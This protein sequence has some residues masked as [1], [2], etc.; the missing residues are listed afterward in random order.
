MVDSNIITLDTNDLSPASPKNGLW[1]NRLNAYYQ[2]DAPGVPLVSIYIIGYNRIEKTKRAVG[3]VLKYTTDIDYEL[4]LIDNGSSDDTLDFFKSVEHPKK[5]I[6]HVTKNLGAGYSFHTVLNVFKGKYLVG[7]SNDIYVTQNWLSNSLK[8]LESDP[9]IGFIEPVSSNVSNLQQHDFTFKDFDEMQEKAAKFNVSDPSKWEE[10]MRLIS[11]LAVFRREILDIVG[12]GDPAFVHDFSEDDMCARIRRAGY[13]LVLCKDTWI[14]HDHDFRH[15]EDKTAETFQATLES[16]RAIYKEKYWGIDAW[17]DMSNFEFNLLEPVDGHT[18]AD[19]TKISAL[20][21]DVKCGTPILEIRN[22][23]R[24]RGMTVAQSFA[25]TTQA[26]YYLDLQTTGA[27]VVCDRSEFIQAHY[28]NN[29]FDIVAI[30]DPINTYPTP[31]MLLQQL[32]NFVKPGGLL[33]FKVCNTDDFNAF[34]RT[35]G[36]GGT[37]DGDLPVVMDLNEVKRRLTLFGAK[38]IS[39]MLEQYPLGVRDRFQLAKIL[40]KANPDAKTED[41]LLTKNFVLKAVKR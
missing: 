37:S 4:I 31:M 23:L 2:Y 9:R 15:L 1:E 33:L 3:Y 10:R 38:G 35:T 28:S 30:G 36:L 14:H 22:R 34:L 16:G 7:V 25:F 19:T 13:K 26:K 27:E 8:C 21:V 24:R 12:I 20:C 40:K 32:Y 6:I 39:I 17:D 5:V 41:I 11:I 18:F 29:G